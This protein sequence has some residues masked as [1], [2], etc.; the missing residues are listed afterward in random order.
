MVQEITKIRKRLAP[1]KGTRAY[2]LVKGTQ[3]TSGMR[4]TSNMLPIG[5]H[6]LE[7]SSNLVANLLQRSSGRV[8]NAADAARRAPSA[9]YPEHTLQQC[10]C[11]P[12]LDLRRRRR[13]LLS[14]S[15]GSTIVNEIHASSRIRNHVGRQLAIVD[16]IPRISRHT[17]TSAAAVIKQILDIVYR[18][19]DSPA[20]AVCLLVKDAQRRVAD[21]DGG[22][23]AGDVLAVGEALVLVHA[24]ELRLGFA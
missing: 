9:V 14:S 15:G 20:A 6:T 24:A 5:P 3:T 23:H 11:N 1:V 22:L 17:P 7:P 8:T 21:C 10:L 2:I 12:L 13:R 4:H 18:L 19:T 16:V